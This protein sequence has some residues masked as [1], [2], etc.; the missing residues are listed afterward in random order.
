MEFDSMP[1]F[2]KYEIVEKI[3]VHQDKVI[4]RVKNG[5]GALYV[6]KVFKKTYKYPLYESLSKL[7][8]ENMPQIHEVA[9]L[10]DCFYVIEDCIAG[11]TLRETLDESGVLSKKEMLGILMQ[12]CDVLGYL[13]S[14]PTP[15]IHRDITPT[16]IMITDGGVV[17]LIDFDIAR[18]H[19]DDATSDTELIGTKH[20]APPEQYGFSQSDQRTDIYALG[21]LMT[22]MGTNTYEVQRVKDAQIASVIER[23]MMLSPDKRFQTVKKLKDRLERINNN[24][25]EPHVKVIA[26]STI[27]ILSTI[28]LFIVLSE[29][30]NEAARNMAANADL[31][32]IFLTPVRGTFVEDF[33]FSLRQAFDSGATDFTVNLPYNFNDMYLHFSPNNLA[34]SAVGFINQFEMWTFDDFDTSGTLLFTTEQGRNQPNVHFIPVGEGFNV[35]IVVTSED[36]TATETYV[37]RFSRQT[38]DSARLR[39]ITFSDVRDDIAG[40]FTAELSPEFSPAIFDY[41]VHVPYHTTTFWMNFG[42]FNRNLPARIYRDNEE[43]WAVPNFNLITSIV[44]TTDSNFY[45]TPY[46]PPEFLSLGYLPAGEEVVMTI[47]V[48]S[49]DGARLETYNVRYI[50]PSADEQSAA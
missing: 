30:I 24:K 10:E 6:A 37:I 11:R 14:Q 7:T 31:E 23:C 46:I 9:L 36:G 43:F 38:A 8:H 50:R 3:A 4:Y 29:R 20:F 32:Y 1:A 2:D 28:A 22:V 12:L 40:D 16:N 39:Y 42:P 33:E 35:S 21:M 19:K 49:E 45:D 41:T 48:F 44:F 18:E 5:G 47:V 27:L 25:P 17:K 15:I 34:S 26:V 13:H